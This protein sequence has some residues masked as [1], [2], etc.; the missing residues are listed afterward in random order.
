MKRFLLIL[1][2]FVSQ[3][4]QA[5][6][7]SVFFDSGKSILSEREKQ[8]LDS[9]IYTFETEL[10][11]DIRLVGHTDSTGYPEKNKQLSKARAIAVYTYLSKRKNIHFSS[12]TGKGSLSPVQANTTDAGRAHNRRCDISIT[13]SNVAPA[14]WVL[15]VQN[16]NVANENKSV[17]YTKNGCKVYVLPGT[18]QVKPTDTVSIQITEYKDPADFIAG[19]LPMSYLKNGHT[20]MFESEQMMKVEAFVDTVPV[21]LMKLLGLQCPDIDTSGGVHFYE[22]SGTAAPSAN[23]RKK[24]ESGRVEVEIITFTVARDSVDVPTITESK[25]E[26][27]TEQKVKKTVV[28]RQPSKPISQPVKK[29]DSKQSGKKQP[30][31]KHIQQ[32]V[33]TTEPD[34]SGKITLKSDTGRAV[35]IEPDTSREFVI[36]PDTG[37]AFYLEGNYVYDWRSSNQTY[38]LFDAGCANGLCDTVFV[39]NMIRQGRRYKG[40]KLLNVP[41]IDFNSYYARYR[42]FAYDG[43]YL[44]CEKRTED[45]YSVHI[46]YKKKNAHNTVFK[47]KS[48]ANNPEY[49]PLKSIKWIIPAPI[50]NKDVQLFKQAEVSD[51]RILP[52]YEYA[53]NSWGS[54]CFEIKSD[55][56]WH[57]FS[58]EPKRSRKAEKRYEL[59]TQL[60]EDRVIAFN[61]SIKKYIADNK[62][63]E[64]YCLYDFMRNLSSNKIISTHCFHTS[65]PACHPFEYSKNKIDTAG[66]NLYSCLKKDAC[67]FDFIGFVSWLRFYNKNMDLLQHELAGLSIHE[68]VACQCRYIDIPPCRSKWEH[69]DVNPNGNNIINIGLGEYNFDSEMRLEKQQQ[70]YD[71]VYLNQQGDTLLKCSKSIINMKSYTYCNHTAYTIIPG[72]NGL[73]KQTDPAV[74]ILLPGK[75]NLL[76]FENHGRKYK[77]YLDLTNI[78]TYTGTVFILTEITEQAST[79]DGLKNELEKTD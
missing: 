79:L 37:R 68:I 74:L 19:D 18:F 30:Q 56:G 41:L 15:P 27:K 70:I 9:L 23:V 38:C 42:N 17:L 13:V 53:Y 75:K 60:F 16:F 22:F 26:E 55:S 76:Y 10:I 35:K 71:A 61:D 47:I 50:T 14:N 29:S 12:I 78:E 6:Q 3:V 1:S 25:T 62:L 57:V 73:L 59:Y 65:L 49:K 46:T 31:Q 44:K 33:K 72:F 28:T 34:V 21:P 63:Q 20:Y 8:R 58:A 4:S 77:L 64:L 40:K 66:L 24:L 43:M 67:I 45:L 51:F 5:Q 69:K 11:Y 39:R 36:I 48:F 32:N 2:L 52:S 54:Y 7:L